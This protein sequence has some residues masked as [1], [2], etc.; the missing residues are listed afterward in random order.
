M[1]KLLAITL[2]IASTS[3]LAYQMTDYTC[4]NDCTNRG[5]MYQYCHQLCSYYT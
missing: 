4:Q 3:V 2:L 5:Y 1:K